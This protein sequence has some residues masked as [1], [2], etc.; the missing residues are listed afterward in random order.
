MNIWHYS[1]RHIKHKKKKGEKMSNVRLEIKGQP[2]KQKV[3]Q[4][5]LVEEKKNLL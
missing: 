5:G 2:E 3:Y 1:I 4:F